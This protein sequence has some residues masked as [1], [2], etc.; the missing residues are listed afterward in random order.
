[1]PEFSPEQ[2]QEWA[3]GHWEGTTPR[4][5]RAFAFDSRRLREGDLFVCLRTEQRDGHEFMDA[6]ASAGAAG[7]LVSHF[8]PEIDLPQ[9]VV[10]DPLRAL[11]KMAQAHRKTF[12]GP[13]VGISGSCGKTSTKDLLALLLGGKPAVHATEG[14][15]NNL[16]G[17]P[18]TLL[19]L[20]AERHQAA[21]VEAGINYPGEMK[22]LAAMIQP[23]HS[24]ITI[25][26]P[27]HLERLETLETVARE[28]AVLP[29]QVPAE[30][31][32]VFP[33]SLLQY[34]PFRNMQARCITPG[35]EKAAPARF[36]VEQQQDKTLVK[37]GGAAGEKTFSVRKVSHGMASNAALA[38]EMARALQVRDEQ[39]QER[40]EKW[41]PAKHRGQFV[42]HG[43][44]RFYVDCYN[45]N[46]S[47]MEDALS[48][49]HELAQGSSPRLYIIGCMGELGRESASYHRK[50]GESLQLRPVDRAFITGADVDAL[51]EGIYAAG[52]QPN[53][54]QCFGNILEIEP[55]VAS[56]EGYVF[57]KGSRVYELETLLSRL[58]EHK[59]ASC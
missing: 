15:L 57:L 42:T 19:A 17:V 47:A 21:V 26:A 23:T 46:P 54:V 3:G 52:S 28:K 53:Q 59:E 30:G 29:Q 24:I 44:A 38:I 55:A 51:R 27:A 6:A 10:E 2:L 11:Q 37:L 25:V 41:A 14:N 50:L 45:A 58:A 5:V 35:E 49:F 12:S 36:S 13:V 34:E 8:R 48:F 9:L 4:P 32:V 39:I 33:Y 7:A 40:L 22:N 20:D 16:I 43:R 18:V 31:V 1:M 56:H